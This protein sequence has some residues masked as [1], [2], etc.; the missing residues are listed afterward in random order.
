MGEMDLEGYWEECGKNPYLFTM[1]LERR[2]CCCCY[3][4]IEKE[5]R[6]LKKRLAYNPSQIDMNEPQK[7]MVRIFWGTV[8]LVAIVWGFIVYVGLIL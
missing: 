2:G 6:R 1:E 7:R 4:C 8:G 3:K 5:I